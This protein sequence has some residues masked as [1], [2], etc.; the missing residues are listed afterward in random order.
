MHLFF[1]AKLFTNPYIL[2]KTGITVHLDI[3]VDREPNNKRYF[4]A[5]FIQYACMYVY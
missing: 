5:L 1:E 3:K 2:F 4:D